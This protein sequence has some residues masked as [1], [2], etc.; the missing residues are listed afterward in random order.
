MALCGNPG[1]S[2][3]LAVAPRALR[4]CRV[5]SVGDG[6]TWALF[7]VAGCGNRACRGHAAG[8]LAAP[9]RGD[10][11]RGVPRARVILRAVTCVSRGRRG[12]SDALTRSTRHWT[13]D[14]RGRCGETSIWTLLRVRF[15]WQVWAKVATGGVAK[16]DSLGQRGEARTQ[17]AFR[18]AGVGNGASGGLAGHRFAWQAQRIVR[19]LNFVALC[20]KSRGR[21]HVRVLGVA[22]SW[23]AQGIRGFVDVSLEQTFLGT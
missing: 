21:A 11:V 1:R 10:W 14:P 17:R 20:D 12:T 9:C 16:V 13:V 5:A 22:K 6:A 7:C 8:V 3:A 15:T 2:D 19:G 23:Q 18:V 4:A